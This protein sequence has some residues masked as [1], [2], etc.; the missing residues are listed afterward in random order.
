[1]AEPA[2]FTHRYLDPGERLGEILFGLIMVLTFTATAR[3]T[4]GDSPDSARELLI[5]A[6]GCNIAWGIIDGGMYIMSAMLERAAEARERATAQGVPVERTGIH[7]DDVKGALACAWL[8]IA[9][10][11]PV[12]LP[13]L[14]FDDALFAIRLSNALLVVMLFLVGYQWGGYA[15]VNKWI[16]GAVFTAVGLVLVAIAIALG[17]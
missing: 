9:T 16:A 6:L 7:G 3:A 13:F 15:N 14:I 12:A 11:F 17:G 2:R 5:A 8:V 4:L 1:L 10:T